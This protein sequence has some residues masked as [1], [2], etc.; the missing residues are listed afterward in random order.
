[1]KFDEGIV[2]LR[3]GDKYKTIKFHDFGKIQEDGIRMEIKTEDI[4]NGEVYSIR[5]ESD[6]KCFLEKIE[7]DFNFRASY[8]SMFSNGYQSMSESREYLKSERMKKIGWLNRIKGFDSYGDYKFV[9]Y[10]KKKGCIHSTGYTYLKSFKSTLFTASLN[11]EKGFTVFYGNIENKKIRVVKDLSGTE[12]ENSIEAL[13]IM[14]SYDVDD[15]WKYYAKLIPGKNVENSK[16]SMWRSF[17]RYGN[18]VTCKDIMKNLDSICENNIDYDIIQIDGGYEANL[19]DWMESSKGFPDGLKF[20]ADKIKE[21]GYIPGI[22]VAPFICSSKSNIYKKNK[23]WLLKNSQNTEVIAG[24][25][26]SLGGKVYAL[27]IQN[28]NFKDYLKNV[29]DYLKECG[30]EF[31]NVDCVYASCMIP[32]NGKNRGMILSEAISYIEEISKGSKVMLSGSPLVNAFK[33]VDYCSVSCINGFSWDNGAE[34][35]SNLK[36][37]RTVCNTLVS[38]LNR[39]KLNKNMF[40]N[41][42]G[43]FT[44]KTKGS[45]LNKHEKYSMLFLSYL[46]GNVIMNSDNIANYNDVEKHMLKS[47]YPLLNLDVYHMEIIDNVYKIKF[48]YSEYSYEVY[49]NSNDAVK[50]SILRYDCFNRHRKDFKKATIID[51]KPHE[52]KY[53]I[54]GN[55]EKISNWS[56]LIVN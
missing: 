52:T 26:S 10:V 12:V 49:F 54:I 1:M 50:T 20:V 11:E 31:I 51:I 3:V 55:K 22:W 8:F 33:K 37:R 17:G 15:S 29:F 40:N 39:Y 42:S 24:R 4:R 48:K 34:R 7:L 36:E 2:K 43:I 21:K 32:G 46:M 16:I 53:F 27:D 23:E 25:D 38:T 35:N 14:I 56:H 30:F 9:D 44:L 47:L 18:D 41:A 13:K 5:I 28:E 6:E 19:G 45:F